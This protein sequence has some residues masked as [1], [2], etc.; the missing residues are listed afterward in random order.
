MSDRLAGKLLV[1]MPGIGDPRF[2]R[3][4]IMMCAHDSK[5]AMG[6]V[7]N[8]PKSEL[9]LND[10]LGHLGVYVVPTEWEE[11]GSRRFLLPAAGCALARL[12]ARMSRPQA[13][14]P[15]ASR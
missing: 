11:A 15:A 9:T 4:V 2:S 3:A 10:V 6:V 12:P 7:I 14:N 5:Q 1:A 13:R 8:K